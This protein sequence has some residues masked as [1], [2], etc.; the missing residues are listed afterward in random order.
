MTAAQPTI[1]ATSIQFRRTLGG[2]WD[3]EAGPV[4]QHAIK[5]ARAGA[6]PRICVIATGV[7]DNPIYTSAFYSAFSRLDLL[8][9]HLALFPCPSVEN[10]REH[11]L[12]QDLIWVSGGSTAN[13]LAIWRLHGVDEVL[14][15]CWQAGIVLMGTSAGSIIWHSG[16][17]TDSFRMPLRALTDGLRFLP[18]S[19]STH[20]NS[21]AD[22]RPLTNQL[23]ADGV[24]P[25]AFAADDGAGLIYYGTDLHEAVSERSAAKCYSITRI[26]EGKSLELELP[27]RLL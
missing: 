8:V 9:S 20:Y 18:Y 2:P 26:A 3:G 22:R 15:D 25:D 5:L 24:I 13:A 16:G 1:I 19:N 12:A 11:L 27:T 21:E 7:G 23:V 10:I 6:H 14:R 4:Y 17:T